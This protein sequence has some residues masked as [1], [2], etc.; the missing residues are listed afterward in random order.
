[1]RKSA[2]KVPSR[3]ETQPVGETSI[4]AI[5]NHANPGSEAAVAL[6]HHHYREG[7]TPGS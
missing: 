1:M 4:E 7:W 5:G 6:V 2:P 3:P